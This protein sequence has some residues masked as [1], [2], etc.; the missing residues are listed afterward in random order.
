M[1]LGQECHVS[2]AGRLARRGAER[3]AGWGLT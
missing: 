1:S 3:Q 2:Q